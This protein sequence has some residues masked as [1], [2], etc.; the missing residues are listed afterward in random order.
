[1]HIEMSASML[2]L[3]AIPLL[4]SVLAGTEAKK[5]QDVLEAAFGTVKEKHEDAPTEEE[6]E[7]PSTSFGV[8]RKVPQLQGSAKRKSSHPSKGGICALSDATIYFPTTANAS[9]SYLHAGVDSAYYSSRKS[10]LAMK[11][12]GYECN[13][14]VVKKAEGISTPECS[15]FST[16][17]GQLSTHIRQYHLG[18]AI[19]CFVCPTKHWWSASAWMEHMKKAHPELGQDAF[20]IKE[21]TGV[22]ESLVIK[23]EV[24]DIDV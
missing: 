4:K 20:F 24:A 1:M 18:L 2:Q 15:F 14:S 22:Q 23:Q 7:E 8:K 13:Y 5:L 21:G 19:G 3:H 6:E 17:K 9:A 12:T 11:S 16:T 10:S